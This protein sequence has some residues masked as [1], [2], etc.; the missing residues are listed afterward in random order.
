[1]R[2][3]NFISRSVMLIGCF[4][5]SIAPSVSQTPASH[6]ALNE[7]DKFAWGLFVELNHPADLSA[8]RGTPD[9]HKQ[10][11][12]PG[13]T[14]WETWKLARTEVY[15]KNG[16]RPPEWD[17]PAATPLAVAANPGLRSGLSHGAELKLFDPPKFS[18]D[19][20][21]LH[22][23]KV[24]AEPLAQPN[25]RLATRLSPAIPLPTVSTAEIGNETRMNRATFDFI[26]NKGLYNIEGQ[27]AL[28]TSRIGIDFPKESREVKAVWREFSDEELDPLKNFK[29]LN[30]DGAISDDE[31]GSKLLGRTF[32]TAFGLKQGGQ[33]KLFGL[34]GMHII[35]K[36]IPNWFWTTFE[37]V[38]NPEPE[39]RNLDR[40]S[41]PDKGFPSEVAG[42]VWQNYRLRGI[43]VDFVTSTGRPTRLGNTQI[44]GGFQATSSCITCHSRASIGQ[45]PAT[46]QGA[47][48]LTVFE[49]IND[50]PRAPTLL[51]IDPQ[52]CAEVNPG[53]PATCNQPRGSTI[54]RGAIGAPDQSLYVV[55]GTGRLEYTQLDFVWSLRRASRRDPS[56][57]NN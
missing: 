24:D 32:H 46:G 5:G 39:I 33:V 2:C 54:I 50:I 11:G 4:L 18:E 26:L 45:K 55:E 20:A 38:Q 51:L 36:D 27:E 1:M 49:D 9:A 17:I 3:V 14:V 41:D 29:D 7:P 10:L 57:P 23:L 8:S 16:C 13:P 35:T 53:P 42:T 6:P 19:I 28:L 31:R 44:E 40:Y 34:S 21:E 43:Q 15:L 56:C 47:N 30:G 37:H 48:R 25:L 12:D 22:G 52:N